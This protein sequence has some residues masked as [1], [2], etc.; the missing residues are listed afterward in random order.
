MNKQ[1]RSTL[2]GCFFALMFVYAGT[3]GYQT[4]TSV[5][6]DVGWGVDQADGR[7]VVEWVRPDGPAASRLRTDDEIVAI[8]NRQISNAIQ[9]AEVQ[10]FAPDTPYSISV[11]RDGQAQ[12]FTLRTAAM[13][14]HYLISSYLLYAAIPAI[15]LLTGFAISLLKPYDKQALLPGLMFGMAIPGRIPASVFIDLPV[16]LAAV[17]V[18]GGMV[19]LLFPTLFA[20]FFLIFPERSPLLRRFP[21][22]NLYLYLPQLLITAPF[23]GAGYFLFLVAPDRYS[24]FDRRFSWL[25]WVVGILQVM[26]I[27]GGLAS[28]LMNYRQASRLSRRKMRVVVAGSLAG[29]LP[30]LPFV[31]IVFFGDLGINRTLLRWY[32]VA[33]IFCFT[34]F[35]LSFAYAVMR[36]QVIP[37][38]WMIRRGIRYV[39]VARGSKVLEA[40]AVAVTLTL[41]L[42]VFF[43]YLETSSRVL[44]GVVSSVI[45]IAVWNVT[46]A[47]HGRV[48]APQIDR[49][50]FRRRYKPQQLLSELGAA[51]RGRVDVREIARLA[52]VKVQEGLQTESA[53]ILLYADKSNDH[54]CATLIRYID[55]DTTVVEAER[56]LTLPADGRVVEQ[57]RRS[58]QLLTIDFDDPDSWVH[59]R[60]ALGIVETSTWREECETLRTIKA[61]LLLPIY[62]AATRD[63]LIGVMAV[64]PRLGDMPFSRDDRQ[65]LL[66]IVWQLALAIEN[67]QLVERRAEEERLRSEMKIAAEVQQRLFPQYPPES[68]LLELSGVCLPARGIGGDYYDFLALDDKR[69]GIAVADVAGKGI[70]AALLMSTVQASLRSCAPTIDGRVTELAT[71]MNRLLHESTAAE[72]YATFFYAQFDERTRQLTYVNAGHNPPLLLRAAV[73]E[74][75]SARSVRRT[76][77]TAGGGQA[78][79]MEDEPG[80]ELVNDALRMLT[81]GGPVIGVFE[82]CNYE[83]ETIEMEPGDVLV[84]YTDG[85]TEALNLAGEEFSE[86][87]LRDI[88]TTGGHLSA[89]E[90]SGRIVE[91]V[92]AWCHDAPQHDDLTLVVAKVK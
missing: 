8:N 36:Y 27:A 23:I 21:R 92:Q 43:G 55:R 90:L 44:I 31:A 34:L 33:A 64:G 49:R 70:C 13:P 85:V 68:P 46:S 91:R 30:W 63:Q 5:G 65:L 9:V 4:L 87:R 24:A 56:G 59:R 61:S 57:L 72:S 19:T 2:V 32:S 58:P 66:A 50:F 86:T 3:K 79:A 25:Y 22:L 35:P 26:Y 62:S 39:L 18:A 80:P 67:A 83:Q 42:R 53:A 52:G 81:T 12:E 76:L 74:R 1:L 20:H 41:F 28:Q 89:E 71:S 48:I 88:I 47:V 37:V 69:V 10:R 73:H 60:A 16:W 82:R 29:F 15:C 38:R 7:V 11:R 17:M 45:S 54:R 51:L 75:Q 40:T 14:L 77:G 78:V 6:S 84:A